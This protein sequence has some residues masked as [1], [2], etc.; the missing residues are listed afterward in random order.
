MLAL[1]SVVDGLAHYENL[2]VGGKAVAVR[3]GVLSEWL[4]SDLCL[5]IERIKVLRY[6][7]FD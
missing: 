7:S 4:W 1:E 6:V 5:P 2:E 3:R